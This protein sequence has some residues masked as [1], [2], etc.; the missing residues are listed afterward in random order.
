MQRVGEGLR[1]DLEL[2]DFAA[3]YTRHKI[4]LCLQVWDRRAK[5]VR[6][7]GEEVADVLDADRFEP[8]DLRRERDA[9]ANV[10]NGRWQT[11]QAHRVH[12]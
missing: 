11:R 10:V 8:F 6:V 5:D 12:A 9:K 4:V 3:P 2:D 7:A 1:E